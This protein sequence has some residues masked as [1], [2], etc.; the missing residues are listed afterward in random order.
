[1]R[2]KEETD[3]LQVQAASFYMVCLVWCSHVIGQAITE[4]EE[5]KRAVYKLVC[6]CVC[7]CVR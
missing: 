4:L 1:M 2:L 5:L 7:V 6:V 3:F